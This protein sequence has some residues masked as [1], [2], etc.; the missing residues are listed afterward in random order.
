MIF[1]RLQTF[2]KSIRRFT[3]ANCFLKFANST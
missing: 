2:G 1:G 3:D